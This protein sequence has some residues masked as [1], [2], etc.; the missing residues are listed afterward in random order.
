MSSAKGDY[1]WCPEP[2]YWETDKEISS[3]QIYANG[4]TDVVPLPSFF[5]IVKFPA[6]EGSSKRCSGNFVDILLTWFFK[7]G[8]K[9]QIVHV[10][11][12]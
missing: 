8:V 4:M 5:F 12:T 11:P 7:V 3:C 9:G 2:G 1:P 10:K 6:V